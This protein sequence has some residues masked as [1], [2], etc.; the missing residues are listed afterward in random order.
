M[1]KLSFLL[2]FI[3]AT[4]ILSSCGPKL[5]DDD[6]VP[7]GREVISVQINDGGNGTDW[8]KK[9]A[10]DFNALPENNEYFV[11]IYPV[12]ED[13]IADI[14]TS[15]E[16]GV[17]SRDAYFT[18]EPN[19]KSIISAELLVNMADFVK[20]KIP[21]EDISIEDKLRYPADV[22][23]TFSNYNDGLYAI[24]YADAFVGF[25]FDYELFLDNGW[26]LG[27]MVDGEYVL[28]NGPDGQPNTY[29]DGQPRNMTE[30]QDMINQI[31]IKSNT[32]PF[33][34]TTK[35]HNYLTSIVDAIMVQYSGLE[36]YRTFTSFNGTFKDSSG[37]TV[38]VTPETGYKVYDIPGLEK[39]I[40]FLDEYLTN[41][42]SYV[43][44]RVWN[45]TETSHRDAQNYFLTGYQTAQPLGA[46]LFE[47]TWWENE[48][49]PMFDSLVANG[50]PNRGYGKRDYRFMMFPAMD[51]Q[52]GI[53]GTGHGSVFNCMDAGAVFAVKN[54][55]KA[56][57]QKVLDFIA[58]TCKDEYLELFT[59][60]S[61]SLRPYNYSLSNEQ[62]A[63]MTPFQQ[64]AYE[65]Y[66]DTDNVKMIRM[67]FDSNISPFYY[68]SSK[69][70]RY[71]TSITGSGTYATIYKSAERHTAAEIIQ[72]MRKYNLDNWSK[73]YAEIKDKL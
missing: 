38:T 72:S 52:L 49:R 2:I 16:S 55:D 48:A 42:K 66:N 70:V 61:G 9:A 47:G 24:P 29:D 28:T 58:Y 14:K 21:G 54:D 32:Y 44:P 53:D 19:I 17:N 5:S 27:E 62:L 30:W 45:T 18:S 20:E 56:K 13:K 41:N 60:I 15:I 1:R 37:N 43:H 46:L 50:Q 6:V 34:F 3:M 8:I 33:V 10:Q 25:V 26:L 11:R 64:N 63:A 12:Q 39:G 57:E 67:N 35:Y 65:I 59:T 73:Y 69:P 22:K 68:E 40:T 31:Q 4:A 36:A 23:T 71:Y 51:G 7:D